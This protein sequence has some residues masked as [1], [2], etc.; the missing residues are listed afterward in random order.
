M[1]HKVVV[2]TKN[3]ARVFTNPQVEEIEKLK[4]RY[5]TVIYDPDLSGVQGVEPHFWRYVEGRIIPMNQ[6]E[7]NERMLD[8]SENGVDNISSLS[9][10]PERIVEVVKQVEVIKEKI[11]EVAV[12][13][14]YVYAVGVLGVASTVYNVLK[15]FGVM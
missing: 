4:S 14:K 10:V 3:N 6:A 13:P 7:R 2:F 8:I 5:E 15:H 12:T 11:V 1:N 9:T